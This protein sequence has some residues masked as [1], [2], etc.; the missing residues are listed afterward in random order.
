FGGVGGDDHQA[1]RP[2][3]RF[4]AGVERGERTVPVGAGVHVQPG[5]SL[6]DPRGGCV[7]AQPDPYRRGFQRCDGDVRGALVGRGFGGR[8]DTWRATVPD[9]SSAETEKLGPA[10]WRCALSRLAMMFGIVPTTPA[11]R[12]VG[13][14]DSG[15]GRSGAYGARQRAPYR[16]TSGSQP[17]P[18]STI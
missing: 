17:I 2:G 7:G 16:A 10:R 12:S 15:S 11:L 3:R 1:G 4:P 9:A 6:G 18:T 14:N 5:R 13:A 8:A